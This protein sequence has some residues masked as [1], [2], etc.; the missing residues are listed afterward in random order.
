M[1][2]AILD[3][4]ESRARRAGYDGFSF[5]D[6]AEEVGITSASVHY[7]FPTKERLVEALTRRYVDR[8]ALYLGDPSALRPRAAVRHLG[9]LF[10]RA[11]EVEDRM[12][13]CGLLAA[14]GGGL[15]EQVRPQVAAFFDLVAKW[16]GVALR[17]AK[18]APRAVEIVAALEG[19]L[20]ISRIR[21]DPAILRGIVSE[22]VKRIEE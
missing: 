11:N 1:K 17:P 2:E 15:P 20:L 6:L 19:G 4:A 18:T 9:A 3:A 8:T 14:E 7:H 13:L 22:T 10:I 21:Q 5:R 12:C 16:L